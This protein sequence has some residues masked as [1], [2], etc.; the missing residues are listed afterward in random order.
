MRLLTFWENVYPAAF[1]IV[2]GLVAWQLVKGV[3]P[4]TLSFIKVLSPTNDVF[5]ILF[6][7]LVAV[8]A[9]LPGSGR[10]Y[11]FAKGSGLLPRLN[12]AFVRALQLCMLSVALSLAGMYAD[13][14]GLGLLKSTWFIV[15]WTALGVCALAATYRAL[16]TALVML[17]K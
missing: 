6:G 9:L 10:V 16:S 17:S 15:A 1:G 8:K 7:F 12:A 14:I 4:A 3:E 13:A 11:D 5:A 2:A